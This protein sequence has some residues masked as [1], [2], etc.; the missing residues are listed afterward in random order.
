MLTKFFGKSAPINY[1]L[2]AIVLLCGILVFNLLLLPTAKPPL[3]IVANGILLV[4]IMLLLDFVIRKNRLNKSNNYG[5]YIFALLAL[6]IPQAA[7]RDHVIWSTLFSLLALRRIFSLYSS[8]NVEKKILD[9]SLWIAIASFFSFYCVLLLPLLYYAIVVQSQLRFSH[10]VIPVL[11]FAATALIFSAIWIILFDEINW[12]DR[13]ALVPQLDFSNYTDPRMLLTLGVFV[14]L[15]IAAVITTLMRLKILNRK[16]R[17]FYVV[18]PLSLFI[19]SLCVLSAV[20][21][22][23]GEWMLLLPMLAAGSATVVESIA[24]KAIKEGLLWLLTLCPILLW[25]LWK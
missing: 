9:A 12:Y 4:F 10:L 2:L 5:I 13:L 8:R 16:V 6:M 20:Q 14:L 11:G 1:L 17:P 3:Q 7:L 24:G 18:L 15:S 23:G 25:I 19:L 21:K 22:D